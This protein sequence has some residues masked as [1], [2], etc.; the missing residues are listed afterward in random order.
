MKDRDWTLYRPTYTIQY[1]IPHIDMP[2]A[3]QQISKLF[4]AVAGFAAFT[5][6]ANCS[7]APEFNHLVVLF[8]IGV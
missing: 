8:C 3:M 7:K 2:V 6:Q 5:L 1:H 4:A